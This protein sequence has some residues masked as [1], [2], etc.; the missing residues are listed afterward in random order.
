MEIKIKKRNMMDTFGIF[1]F[2]NDFRLQL[3]KLIFAS[4]VTSTDVLNSSTYTL[5][6]NETF[7]I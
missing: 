1:F 4:L 3:D 7:D 6:C 5:S 2:I